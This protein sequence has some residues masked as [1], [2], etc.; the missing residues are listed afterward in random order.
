MADEVVRVDAGLMREIVNSQTAAFDDWRHS[1]EDTPP[2]DIPAVAM[3]VID[4]ADSTW[5][6][7]M[8]ELRDRITR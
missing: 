4:T 6:R 2:A 3:M 7:A 8:A 5:T 1:F